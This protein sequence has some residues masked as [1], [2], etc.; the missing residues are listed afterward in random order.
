ME[1]ILHHLGCV[2]PYRYWFFVLH[3][4]VQDSFHQQYH[5]KGTDIFWRWEPSLQEIC[6]SFCA[7]RWWTCSELAGLAEAVAMLYKQPKQTCFDMCLGIFACSLVSK[8]T[9]SKSLKVFFSVSA[10]AKVW[11]VAWKFSECHIWHLSVVFPICFCFWGTKFSLN[12]LIKPAVAL[13]SHPE[14]GTIRCV[15]WHRSM[16]RKNGIEIRPSL[17]KI[18]SGECHRFEHPAPFTNP[19]YWNP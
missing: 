10:S 8:S 6:S 7:T 18:G 4:L 17:A 11:F 15:A 9:N 16:K 12:A 19:L 13:A 1:E 3:Q 14:R 2:R 5:V